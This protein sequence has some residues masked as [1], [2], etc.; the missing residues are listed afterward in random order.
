MGRDLAACRM[1]YSGILTFP[2]NTGE[3]YNDNNNYQKTATDGKE[4]GA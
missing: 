2:N 3:R 1:P 4:Y